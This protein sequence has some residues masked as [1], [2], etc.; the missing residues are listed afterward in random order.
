[1]SRLQRLVVRLIRAVVDD[2]SYH[3]VPVTAND[4]GNVINH[5]CIPYKRPGLMAAGAGCCGSAVPSAFGTVGT[6]ARDEHFEAVMKVLGQRRDAGGSEGDAAKKQIEALDSVATVIAYR[7]ECP[8]GLD[9]EDRTEGQSLLR[10]D[11]ALDDDEVLLLLF[12]ELDKDRNGTIEVS[13]LLESE[14]LNK[15]ENKNIAT[16]LRRALGCNLDIMKELLAPIEL[17]AFGSYKRDTKD[18]S[19]KCIFEEAV[20]CTAPAL[21]LYNFANRAGLERLLEQMQGVKEDEQLVRVL[22]E[23][24]EGL[25][26]GDSLDFLGLKAAAKQLPR[27]SGQRMS[28]ASSLCLDAAL[29]RHVPPGTLEDG[30][31]GLKRMDYASWKRALDAFCAD[32]RRTVETAVRQVQSAR[33]STSAVE[34]NSKFEGFEGTFAKLEE[35]HAGAEQTLQLGYPNPLVMKGI[36]NEHTGLPSATRLFVTPSYQLATC[37]LLEYWWAKG[38]DAAPAEISTLL[39]DLR[40]ERCVLCLVRGNSQDVDIDSHKGEVMIRSVCALPLAFV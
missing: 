9:E 6:S 25:Q 15:N 34:A 27:V 13:E 38:P 19:V 20:R 40:L 3:L 33:G 31:A 23:H 22:K 28:W 7:L 30:L 16:V 18:E 32:A 26:V 1:M 4:D 21:E 11:G 5:E 17:T 24:V 29:A 36:H 14:H 37:L 35:Y 12:Q 10:F 8:L 39:G 2:S